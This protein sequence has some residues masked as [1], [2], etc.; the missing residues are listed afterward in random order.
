[1]GEIEGSGVGLAIVK[2]I[3]NKHKGQI[4]AESVLGKG[5]VFHAHFRLPES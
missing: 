2:R 5:T 1:M 4:W 3:M